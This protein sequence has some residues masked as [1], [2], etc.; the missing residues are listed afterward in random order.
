MIYRIFPRT[1]KRRCND[2]KFPEEFWTNKLTNKHHQAT[3]TDDGVH[4]GLDLG[5]LHQLQGSQG[6]VQMLLGLVTRAVLGE[7]LDTVIELQMTMLL[8]SYQYKYYYEHHEQN[9]LLF[10]TA[11]NRPLQGVKEGYFNDILSYGCPPF[12]KR[13]ILSY[14]IPQSEHRQSSGTWN[15]WYPWQ[16]W[17][18]LPT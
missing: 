5:G 7:A 16:T 3:H 13:N 15:Q 10:K 1:L 9:M 17:H 2:L 14:L 18:Y 11:C 6:G 4:Q 8:V 12:A